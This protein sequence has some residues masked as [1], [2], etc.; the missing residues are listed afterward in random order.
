MMLVR[1]PVRGEENRG[2]SRLTGKVWLA[3]L[4]MSAIAILQQPFTALIDLPVSPT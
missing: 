1:I 2:G 3:D 4:S